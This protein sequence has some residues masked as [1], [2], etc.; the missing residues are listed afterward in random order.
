ME[1]GTQIP[2]D[3]DNMLLRG[4]K[5][6]NTRSIYGVVVFTGKESKIMKNTQQARYKFSTLEK[7]SNQAI[8]LVL[9]TQLII[10][11]LGSS[12]G[13]GW[14]FKNDLEDPET[15]LQPAYYLASETLDESPMVKLFLGS[16]TWVMIF[17]NMV[18]ISLM[19]QLEICKLAQA[20]F[21]NYDIEMYDHD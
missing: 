11:L 19:L 13:T 20:F 1:N 2:L 9:I 7:M 14:E 4:C 5:L 17:T 15:K 18:P 10:S 21:M 12:V 8:G 16:L 3:A 6:R